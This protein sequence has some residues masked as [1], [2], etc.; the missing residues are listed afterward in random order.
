MPHA[1]AQLS[2]T[3]L[4]LGTYIQAAIAKRIKITAVTEA[5]Q[6]RIN[7][8]PLREYNSLQEALL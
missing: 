7:F 3:A 5:L 6:I 1:P 8:N 4:H 2:L